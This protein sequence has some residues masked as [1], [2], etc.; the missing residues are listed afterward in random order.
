MVL[1]DDSV[2]ATHF[3]ITISADGVQ[4][5]DLGSTNGTWTG[6]AARL[7]D[8]SITLFDGAMFF[9]GDTKLRICQID[10]GRV[11]RSDSPT[12]GTMAGDSP[13][14]REIFALIDRVAP[15]PIKTLITGETGT[16]KEEVARTVHALSGRKGPF[17]VLDCGALP[18]G[19]AESAIL[20]HDKGAFTGATEMRPGAFEAAD[21]GTVFLDEIGELPLDLQP[22][23]LRVLDGRG[24]V[25]VGGSVC[26]PV[27]VRV[28]AAT[29]RDLPAL[30]AEGRFRRDLYERLGQYE[31]CLPPLRERREDIAILARHFLAQVGEEYGEAV[32]SGIDEAVLVALRDR[33]WEGNV[34]ALRLTIETLAHLSSGPVISMDDLRR[35]A[36]RHMVDETRARDMLASLCAMSC[37]EADDGF[38][39]HYLLALAEECEGH[40]ERM[41][42]RAGLTR[43]GLRGRHEK[44]GLP[45]PPKRG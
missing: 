43:K 15:T 18:S 13:A 30:I 8:G 29:H 42:E 24:I 10:F 37:S 44:L 31:L 32:A 7:T 39:R 14:M 16:G 22:K 1:E 35:F 17:V 40:V 36:R 45:W 25:R 19:L 21:G 34:R 11:A 9:A 4:L 20:G 33:H 3:E 2:S 6:R 41:C 26:G 12:L 28:L 27:D 38:Q 23:L 5:R